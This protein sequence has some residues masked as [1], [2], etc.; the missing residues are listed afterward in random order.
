MSLSDSVSKREFDAFA[1]A[2][3]GLLTIQSVYTGVLIR[4][5][6]QGDIEWVDQFTEDEKL[7]IENAE[8]EVVEGITEALYL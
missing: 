6:E 4:L 8:Q 5:A 7:Q 2:T 1:K 3:M